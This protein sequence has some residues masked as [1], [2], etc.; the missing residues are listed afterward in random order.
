MQERTSVIC[1]KVY[2]H[3]MCP[4]MFV[5]RMCAFIFLHVSHCVFV[6]V[7]PC[8]FQ[9][10][11][12]RSRICSGANPHHSFSDVYVFGVTGFSEHLEDFHPS[13]ICFLYNERP[14][15][16]KHLQVY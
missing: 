9:S 12:A 10:G 16:W 6:C 3:F 2:V 7:C 5:D 4:R 8:V 11:A 15:K 14:E 1:V 13:P